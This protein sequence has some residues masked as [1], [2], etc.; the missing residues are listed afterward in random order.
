M[1]ENLRSRKVMS[2]FLACVLFADL[3][4]VNVALAGELERVETQQAKRTQILARTATQRRFRIF[5][6]RKVRASDDTNGEEEAPR[7]GLWGRLRAFM[8]DDWAQTKS[9]MAKVKK[10]MRRPLTNFKIGWRKTREKLRSFRTKIFRGTKLLAFSVIGRELSQEEEQVHMLL[11][12]YIDQHGVET[13]LQVL[14]NSDDSALEQVSLAARKVDDK[15]L[16]SQ[17]LQRYVARQYLRMRRD[18]ENKDPQI[19]AQGIEKAEEVAANQEITDPDPVHWQKPD[20]FAPAPV[21]QPYYPFVQ[22]PQAPGAKKKSK[23]SLQKVLIGLIAGAGLVLAGYFAFATMTIAPFLA[24]ISAV[25]SLFAVSK[26]M[27]FGQQVVVVQQPGF[28]QQF[29]GPYPTQPPTAE[30]PPLVE[31]PDDLP[32]LPIPPGGGASDPDPVP[33]PRVVIPAPVPQG[34][35]KININ[36]ATKDQL[37]ELPG[38]GPATAK[39]LMLIRKKAAF[40]TTDDLL[41]IKGF[42]PKKVRAMAPYLAF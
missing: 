5:S 40:R 6:S 3:H 12:A 13:L 22:N 1:F 35:M 25:V 39:K 19:V 30:P 23:I 27:N 2:G 32:P 29:P 14:D 37:Q 24:F 36:T 26:R 4:L 21:Y 10:W 17:L 7:K 28:Q 9:D 34:G 8:A 31:V 20:E 41:R 33:A 42:G 15:V 11:T 16:Q 38:V 18:L